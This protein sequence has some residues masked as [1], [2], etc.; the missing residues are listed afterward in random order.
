M[1]ILPQGSVL[2]PLFYALYIN[3]MYRSFGSDLVRL[4]ADDTVL[5]SEGNNLMKSIADV[6]VKFNDL[7]DWCISNNL[8]TNSEKTQFIV[9]H[10]HNK[11]MPNNLWEIDTIRMKIKR[12][13]TMKY[14]SMIFVETWNGTTILAIYVTLWFNISEYLI[15]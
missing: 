14:I 6:T 12:V 8:T 7:Y 11:T 13:N 3:D 9:F 15:I 2:G 4:F 5:F 1:A 10:I